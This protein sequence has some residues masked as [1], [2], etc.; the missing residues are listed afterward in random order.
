VT[1]TN[2]LPS[3]H[4]TVHPD[5]GVGVLEPSLGLQDQDSADEAGDQVSLKNA[6]NSLPINPSNTS[7]RPFFH[8][9]QDPPSGKSKCKRS[10][11]V[12]SLS[13]FSLKTRQ[14]VVLTRPPISYS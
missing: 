8:L 2:N 11:A 12:R 13:A 9:R 7:K 3:P 1:S 4:S 5:V 10:D 14:D 6:Y